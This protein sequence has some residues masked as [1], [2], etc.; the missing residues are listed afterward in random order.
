MT[1][2]AS[3]LQPQTV[4]DSFLFASVGDDENGMGVSI[5]SAFARLDFDPWQKAEEFARLPTGPARTKLAAMI[6]ALPGISAAHP[7]A[8]TIAVRLIALLPDQV[9]PAMASRQS[10]SAGQAMDFRSPRFLIPLGLLIAFSLASQVVMAGHQPQPTA[11]GSPAR[12]DDPTDPQTPVSSH[13]DAGPG[14]AR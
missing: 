13:G 9:P 11:N 4:F 1:F 6:A 8:E 3:I 14:Q 12:I 2:A 7:Q 10:H 5:L